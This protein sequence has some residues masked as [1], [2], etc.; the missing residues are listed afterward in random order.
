MSVLLAFLSLISMTFSV[1]AA[2]DLSIFGGTPAN[3]L[4]VDKKLLFHHHIHNFYFNDSDKFKPNYFAMQAHA[5]AM[6]YDATTHY[7][8]K[9]LPGNLDSLKRILLHNAYYMPATIDF[10]NQKIKYMV[11]YLDSNNWSTVNPERKVWNSYRLSD[12]DIDIMKGYGCAQSVKY[13][14]ISVSSKLNEAKKMFRIDKD[15]GRVIANWQSKF[16]VQDL[17]EKTILS[18]K[19]GNYDYLF[20]DDLPRNPGDCINKNFGGMGAYNTW[21]DGQLAFL[22]KVTD[23]AHSM[24]GRQGMKIKVFGNIWSP[25]ADVYSSKWYAQKELRLDHYYFESGGFARE[26]FLHGQSSNSKDPET[27]LP[28]FS[29]FMGGFIPANIVSVGTHIK[30]M[31]SLAAGDNVFDE[32]MLQHYV[33]AG[34]AA[35]QGSWF[36]WYGE[37]SVDKLGLGG[38]RIHT[39]AMQLLRAIPNWENLANVPLDLRKYDKNENI[40]FS[41]NSRFSIDSIQGVNPLN[42][43]VYV[44]FRATTGKIHLL[45]KQIESAYFVNEN[46]N[47]TSEDALPCLSANNGKISFLCAD[48]IDKGIRITTTK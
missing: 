22:K 47:T 40:Y 32:Y 25:Y 36:G 20:F 10:N 24:L 19:N 5:L 39:N 8:A 23:A 35:R 17:A 41:P 16:V 45:E 4:E 14:S 33:A 42:N 3:E 31:Y 6:N 27:D 18:L 28:A 2:T 12:E 46:F 21:K 15:Y 30:T 48:K 29:P 9:E 38:K 7:L 11:S 34:I 1:N 43:E 13:E 26:D 37:T 44:V